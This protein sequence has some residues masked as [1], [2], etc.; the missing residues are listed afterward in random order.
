ML[1]YEITISGAKISNFSAFDLATRKV[2]DRVEGLKLSHKGSKLETDDGWSVEID[3][4]TP[5]RIIAIHDDGNGNRKRFRLRLSTGTIRL[6]SLP[7]DA[8]WVELITPS[9][10][11]K[12][13]F[14]ITDRESVD[15]NR[16]FE[17]YHSIGDGT[18]EDM[19]AIVVVSDGK[20]ETTLLNDQD[21]TFS[22]L[23]PDDWY[24]YQGEVH[25][26]VTGATWAVVVEQRSDEEGFHHSVTLYT[27]R[28]NLH[29]LAVEL[30]EYLQNDGVSGFTDYIQKLTADR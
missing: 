26:D 12:K 10:L 30:E 15:P 18:N 29:L 8:R 4:T 11:L 9:T 14:Q 2:L 20:V 5:G 24:Y 23:T 27:K 6:Q 17:G 19:S 16:F 22:D 3:H 1:D 25:H 13:Q 28:P 7:V 21:G